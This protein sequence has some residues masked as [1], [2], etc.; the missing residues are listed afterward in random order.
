MKA[1]WGAEWDPS[2]ESLAEFVA[3]QGQER[4]MAEFDYQHENKRRR[5]RTRD[6]EAGRRGGQRTAN[7]RQ[8]SGKAPPSDAMDRPAVLPL[9]DKENAP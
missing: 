5:L 4:Q 9:P 2:H 6:R 3:R 7:G 8:T 1:S